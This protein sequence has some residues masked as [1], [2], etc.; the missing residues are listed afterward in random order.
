MVKIKCQFC[1]NRYEPKVDSRTCGDIKCIR[2]YR[3]N[4]NKKYNKKNI[5][6]YRKKQRDYARK[7]F[8]IKKSNWRV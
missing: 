5:E 4:Y 7:K 1:E 6:K 2:K 8:K 3:N